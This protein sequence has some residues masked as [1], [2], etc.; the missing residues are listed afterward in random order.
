[1]AQQQ[2]ER[3]KKLETFEQA[4]DKAIN[5]LT[6]RFEKPDQNAAIQLANALLVNQE[7]ERFET[8]PDT[9]NDVPYRV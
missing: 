4:L 9:D 8:R 6:E 7:R 1:M 2:K 5:M 3:P